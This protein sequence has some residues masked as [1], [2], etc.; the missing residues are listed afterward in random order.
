MRSAVVLRG[1][2]LLA[3]LL[4][5]GCG[6]DRTQDVRPQL[7][8]PPDVVEFGDVP[9]LNEKRLQIDVQNVGRALLPVKRVALL[10][11]DVPFR[12]LS[13]PEEVG[14]ADADIIEVAFVQPLE[15]TYEAPLI[16]GVR[17]PEHP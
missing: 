14:P 8:P 5:L 7:V 9:V 16:L 2:G 6:D 1:A 13:S 4:V 15:G 3:A 17:S 10:E 12:L 11:D